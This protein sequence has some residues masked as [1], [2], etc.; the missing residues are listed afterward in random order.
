MAADGNVKPAKKLSLKEN[1]ALLTRDLGWEPSY[2]KK[3]DVFRYLEFEGIKIHDWDKWEDPF[4]LTMDA[5][6]KYQGEKEKKLY[7][8][9]DAF[10][11]GNGQFNVTDARYVQALKLFINA[12]VELEYA[13]HRGFC[14]LSREFA[15]AAPRIAAQMQS[16]DELRHATTQIHAIS[17]YN[18]YFEGMANFPYQF[19]RVWYLSIPK[20]FFEDAVTS[21]P[22]EFI[23][24]I[25]FA[26]EYVLTNLVFMPWMSGAAYNG[27]MSTVSFGFS[28][29]SDEARH[30]T[31]GI[32]VIKFLLEQDPAN[33]PIVQKWIDKWFWRGYRLLALLATMMDYILPKRVM[34]WGEAW[35]IYYEQNGG[36]LFADL[37]RYGIKPPKYADVTIAEK[38]RVSHE[39]WSVFYTNRNAVGFP[40]WLPSAEE[41]DWFSEKYGETFDKYYR[42]RYEYYRQLEEAGTPFTCKCLPQLCQVCQWPCLYTEKDDPTEF[43]HSQTEYKGE[44]FHF[45][46]HGCHD[47]FQ[48]EPEKYVHAWMPVNQIYQGNCFLPG[49]DPT[50]PDFN[51]MVE[52]LKYMGLK[53]GIDGGLFK[54]HLDAKRWEEWTS[55]PANIHEGAYTDAVRDSSSGAAR[56]TA[57]HKAA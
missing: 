27:D 22:F 30:M 21:G 29:Q 5:Y 44:I 16:I 10:Q 48:D 43:L 19:D 15:G 51:P 46:S 25:S 36:A 13:S 4:R 12:V 37:A 8:I 40:V 49:V 47:I 1:Y 17:H 39:M 33:V 34:S 38:N 41:M 54:E 9:I 35:E 57:P 45:C 11:Q 20:S 18:K 52:A 55:R 53:P 7:A 31:L 14:I 2:Q 3:E 23:V 6:W 26:F 56:T 42:P 50:A 32:E 28:A 24:A